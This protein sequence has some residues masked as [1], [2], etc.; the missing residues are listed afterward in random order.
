MTYPNGANIQ[1]LSDPLPVVSPYPKGSFL[2]QLDNYFCVTER[3]ST[4]GTEVRAG[5]V[6]FFTMAYILVLN[7]QILHLATTGAHAPMPFESVVTAT[8]LSSFLATLLTGLFANL[9]F[10]LAPGM[11]LNSYFTYGMCLR[12]G[13]TWQQGL[14]CCFFCGLLF[15]LLSVTGACTLVQLYVPACVKKSITVGLG[16]FQALIGL[17]VAKVVVAGDETLLQLGD[18]TDPRVVL[19]GAGLLLIAVLM[20]A[21]VKAAMIVGLA[22]ITVASWSLGIQTAP[23]TLFAMP[24][25]KN[26]I[27]QMD[28]AGYFHNYHITVPITLIILFVCIFDTAGVQF[29]LGHQGGL[30]DEHHNLPG[31]GAAFTAAS[32][33]T[34]AGACLGTSPVIIHNESC[35]GIEDGARTGLSSLV[36]AAGFLLILPFMPILTAVPHFASAAPLIIV[37]MLMM[38]AAKFID[39]TKVE[40]ALPA[41]L[42]LTILPLTYSIANGMVA[43]LAAYAVLKP[44][45]MLS[46]MG[47]GGSGRADSLDSTP[48]SG[49]SGS[50]PGQTPLDKKASLPAPLFSTVYAPTTSRSPSISAVVRRNSMR[51]LALGIA[52]GGGP[53]EGHPSHV[54]R[55]SFDTTAGAGA[56]RGSF[57]ASGSFRGLGPAAGDAAAGG[58]AAGRPMVSESTPFLDSARR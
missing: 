51:N 34:M 36:V 20:V 58:A 12:L 32:V 50:G 47:G 8:A 28:F 22:G 33:A 18:L 49:S 46:A 48:S 55:D 11:G 5:L 57:R 25:L 7:A 27:M 1:S 6:T 21:R 10:G 31:A 56:G 3:D 39:W 37:G 43:G 2:E 38:S 29:A 23:T 15:L 9:P 26:T 14:A 35:A 54:R 30:L 24:S 42:T 41:F 16:L 40:D 19:S 44:V 52:G 4:V 13:M 53:G 45:A 17:E